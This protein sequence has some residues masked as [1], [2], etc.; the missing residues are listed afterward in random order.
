MKRIIAGFVALVLAV[1]PILAALPAT[2]IWEINAGATASN[3]NGGGFNPGNANFLTDLTTD[4]NTGDTSAPVVQS[5]SYNFAAGDVG[6]WLYVS[7]GTNWYP[8]WYQIQSVA[9]NKATLSAVAGSTMAIVVTGLVTG[10]ANGVYGNKNTTG[11]ASVGTPTGG[12]FGIDYSQ[13]TTSIINNTDLACAD[14]DA[15]SPAVTSAGSP[16]GVQHVGNY[17]RVSAGTGYTTGWYQ[18]VS[19]SGVTATLDRAVGTDGAKT[20]GTFRVGGALSFNSTLDDDVMEAGTAGQ[21]VFVKNNGTVSVG[22]TVSVAL[23]GTAAGAIMLLGY[24]SYRGDAPTG[25]SRPLLNLG[26]SAFTLGTRWEIENIRTTATGTSA[27]AIGNTGKAVNVKAMN[28]STTAARPAVASNTNT[29]FFGVEAISWRGIGISNGNTAGIFYGVIG[30]DSDEGLRVA[31]TGSPLVVIIN[32]IFH[33]NK[34]AAIRMTTT[35]T[36]PTTINNCTLYGAENKLGIGL[37]VPTGA[38]SQAIQNSIIY[39]FVTGVSLAD[40]NSQGTDNYN[41]YYNNTSDVSSAN[42]WQKGT[43]TIAVDPVFAN[44][45]QV[46]GTGATSSTNVLTDGSK[47]FTALGVTT[48][49]HVYLATGTGTGFTTAIFGISSVGTTT[50]T[51]SSNITSSGSGSGIVYQLTLGNNFSPTASGVKGAGFPGAFQGGY[52]TGTMDIGAVQT[53]A[54]AGNNLLGVIQ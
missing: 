24:N 25:D 34:T 44:V 22:E 26:T 4:T 2:G 16:F 5:A 32:S 37:S 20:G 50:L 9:S 19:V 7:T 43:N 11:I 23:A 54:G 3:V 42:Q 35:T 47:D 13:K 15:A 49:D 39:G 1:D 21:V 27:L 17:I 41:A 31:S 14:G 33:S 48:S 38:T 40:N 12:T 8:G 53:P 18:I 36:G 30:H 45:T 52:T 6:H 46:T 10:T 28:T 51:L 29:Q